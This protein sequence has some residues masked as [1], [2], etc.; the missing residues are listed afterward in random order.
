MRVVSKRTAKQKDEI[1]KL[2]EQNK[3]LNEINKNMYMKLHQLGNLLMD[4]EEKNIQEINKNFDGLTD[5]NK[6]QMKNL[7]KECKI[8]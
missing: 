2:K 4:K 8:F 1:Q 5:L 6:D 7:D 3:S